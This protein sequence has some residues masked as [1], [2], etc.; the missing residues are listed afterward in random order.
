MQTV[1]DRYQNVIAQGCLTNS[2]HPRS[3]IRGVYPPVVRCAYG[4]TVV[5]HNDRA[6][7]DYICGLGTNLLGYGNAAVAKRIVEMAG[8][9]YSPSFG[10]EAE[11]NA[12]E[13]LLGLFPWAE[14][15]KFCKTGSIACDGAVKIARAHTGRKLVLSDGY[16]GHGDIFIGLTEPALGVDRSPHVQKLSDYK[17]DYTDVAAVIIEPIITDDSP[18]RIAWLRALREATQKAGAM[19]IFDEVI[20]GFRWLKWSVSNYFQIEPDLLCL[21]KAIGGGMPL[22]AILGRTDAMNKEYFLSSTYAG[23][24][25]SLVACQ[26]VIHQLTQ[27]PFKLDE[28]WKQAGEFRDAMNLACAG[29]VQFEGYNTRGVIKA[30]DEMKKAL[31]FQEMCKAG[32]IFGPSW[33]FSFA[34]FRHTEG[35][36]RICEHVVDKIRVGG[37]RLEGQLPILPFAQKMREQKP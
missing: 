4:A 25:L 7:V 17:G 11:V 21:G 29:V 37:A 26:E 19:L 30:D 20:T 15:V 1:W 18:E 6:Y 8:L 36:L 10:T 13:K 23:E 14:K 2:K 35:T 32:V 24:I 28:L 27:G 9:G 12:A 22:A 5:D 34:H 33:F 31:F 16:H 3:H